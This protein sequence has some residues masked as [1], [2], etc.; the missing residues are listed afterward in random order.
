[1]N[2]LVI[3]GGSS[4]IKAQLF[5]NDLT[6]LWRAQAESSDAS[7][8]EPL[9]RQA[10]GG[11]EVHAAGHRIVHG[12][13]AFRASTRITAEVK[14]AIKQLASF[15]PEHNLLEVEAIEEAERLMPPGTPQIAVFDTAF[16]ANL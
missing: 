4:S 10:L 12:G 11:H 16:H 9:I 7:A 6:V 1:M 15:A 8:I 5:A 14:A 3:N 13:K 2:I